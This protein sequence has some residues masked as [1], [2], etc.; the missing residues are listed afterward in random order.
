[1]AKFTVRVSFDDDNGMLERVDVDGDV[2]V[3][4]DGSEY[5]VTLG[6]AF[7]AS[8]SVPLGPATKALSK[9]DQEHAES[10]LADAARKAGL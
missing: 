3:S 6:E 4:P 2:E 9:Y 1:M 8:W 5:V 7:S 10:E